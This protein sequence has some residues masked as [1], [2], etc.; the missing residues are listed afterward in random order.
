MLDGI[1]T[2]LDYTIG[3][4][5]ENIQTQ[6]MSREFRKPA[7]TAEVYLN[8]SVKIQTEMPGLY[9]RVRDEVKVIHETYDM[10]NK[11]DIK[12]YPVRVIV[13]YM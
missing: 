12:R 1:K 7:V 9:A 6:L 11:E 4:M 8:A 5:R 13:S 2:K 3:Y 10:K